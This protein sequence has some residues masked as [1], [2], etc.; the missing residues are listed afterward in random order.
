MAGFTTVWRAGRSQSGNEAETGSLHYGSHLRRTRLRT[1]DRSTA[2][3]LG[4]MSNGQFTWQAPFSLR[5]LPSF[6]W[7]T[8]P[9]PV[10]SKALREKK[11]V[12]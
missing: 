8:T 7:R 5:D 12:N 6:A 2:R 11:I 9:H 1:P 3:S 4:Y 10:K